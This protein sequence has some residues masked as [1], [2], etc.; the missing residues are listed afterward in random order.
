MCNLPLF[1]H[2]VFMA[3]CE[4][5]IPVDARSAGPQKVTSANESTSID[6]PEMSHSVQT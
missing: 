4:D 6:S 3:P 5:R 2:V 1:L